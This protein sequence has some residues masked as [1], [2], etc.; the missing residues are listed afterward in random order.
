DLSLDSRLHR[1]KKTVKEQ[2]A[3]LTE[4]RIEESWNRIKSNDN[5]SLAE[6]DNN[7]LSNYLLHHLIAIRLAHEAGQISGNGKL[8]VLRKAFR[9][10]ALAQSFLVDAFSPAKMLIDRKS[11]AFLQI[12]NYQ[13]IQ[14]FF[15]KKGIY[16]YNSKG[17][18]WQSF[19]G[20]LMI[21]Y[22]S[23]YR[24]VSEASRFSILEVMLTFHKSVSNGPL[25]SYLQEFEKQV[26]ADQPSG[27]W[28]G[29]ESGHVYYKQMK[30]P[31]LLCLPS[32]LPASWSKRSEEIDSF[33]IAKRIHKPQ[34]AE[35]GQH[36]PDD[37]LIE[38]DFLPKRNSVP[39]FLVFDEFKNN[40]T[41]DSTRKI[42]KNNPN[43]ASVRYNQEWT[44][45][46]SYKGLLLST[47]AMKMFR[48]GQDAFSFGIGFGLTQDLFLLKNISLH[49]HYIHVED[50]E[51]IDILSLEF[52]CSLPLPGKVFDGIRL[53]FGKTHAYGKGFNLKN[54][55]IASGIEFG[56]IPLGFTYSAIR[57][58]LMIKRITVEPNPFGGILLQMILQ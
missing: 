11:L 17:D 4:E 5:I 34:F 16:V 30:M 24:F 23:S 31:S 50:V 43:I 15:R 10:E 57:F 22:E 58:R 37:A 18:V 51:D 25:P 28:L 54:H 53:E 14:N 35:P 7:V 33:G 36:D 3:E 39:E 6:D 47:A 52:G 29:N 13:E 26:P 48:D 19:G 46:P 40:P 41:V 32:P 45:Q 56:A 55:S 42:I 20:G 12:F 2:L 1:Y 44:Y 9:I 21:A 8:E 38:L 49:A 27:Y